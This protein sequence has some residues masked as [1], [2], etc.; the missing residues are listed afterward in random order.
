M[1]N[2]PKYLLFAILVFIGIHACTKDTKSDENLLN[3]NY[4]KISEAGI[5]SISVKLLGENL[6]GISCTAKGQEGNIIWG[7]KYSRNDCVI[8]IDSIN[9]NPEKYTLE[10]KSDL[11]NAFDQIERYITNLHQTSHFGIDQL[12]IEF[13]DNIEFI[14]FFY[15][16]FEDPDTF[17]SVAFYNEFN[18]NQKSSDGVIVNCTGS[19]DGDDEECIEF[20]N[21][22][23]FDI[24]CK[25]VSD[26]CRL[27]IIFPTE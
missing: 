20:Y 12:V 25:C 5:P 14:V 11:E 8:Q 13:Y 19:C 9:P 17:Y 3:S 24:G 22:V 18:A 2:E 23:T 10:V 27:E 4:L 1:K 15:S 21:V 7:A 6:D 16:I 26:S